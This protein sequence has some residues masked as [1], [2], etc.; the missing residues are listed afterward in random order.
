MPIWLL[1]YLPH[2]IGALV[3]LGALWGIHRHG[4][5]AGQ[6]ERTAHYQPILTKV[7]QE[8][9]RAEG[10]VKAA[11]SAG[12]ALSID[13]EK[14]LAESKKA[15]AASRAAAER[16]IA[17]LVRRIT[18]GD[19][20]SLPEAPPDPAEPRSSPGEFAR[21]GRIG[22]DFSALAE[23]AQRDAQ[24]LTACQDLLRAE[25]RLLN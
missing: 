19:A 8:R 7:D 4:Y 2:L 3:I 17:D 23:R 14:R 6:A 5:K 11:E 18:R 22:A 10:R 20:C 13:T 21:F 1:R 9:L 15:L 16:R 24:R 12:A 25:R